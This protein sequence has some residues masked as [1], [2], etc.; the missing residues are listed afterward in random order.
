M[1]S[2]SA[3]PVLILACGQ[4]PERFG[5]KAWQAWDEMAKRGVRIDNIPFPKFDS[6]IHYDPFHMRPEEVVLH[7]LNPLLRDVQSGSRVLVVGDST[8]HY[9]CLKGWSREDLAHY[10]SV[11]TGM[12]I[13]LYSESGAGFVEKPRKGLVSFAD[14]VAQYKDTEQGPPDVMLIIGGWNDHREEEWWIRT[15]VQSAISVYGDGSDR[16]GRW[17]RGKFWEQSEWD[18]WKP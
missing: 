13:L 7:V 1:A 8:T 16:P 17:Y 15:R 2:T 14:Q 6:R 10:Y 5:W 4:A 12:E 11:F 9:P 3:T 18:S